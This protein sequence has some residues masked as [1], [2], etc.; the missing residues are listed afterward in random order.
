MEAQGEISRR[1]NERLV[2]TTL[3]VLIDSVG[4]G[5]AVG[6]TEKDAPEVDNEVVIENAAGLSSGRFYDVRIVDAEEYDL[7]GAVSNGSQTGPVKHEA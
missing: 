6:R 5:S 2:G 1:K 7:F 3:K 4:G